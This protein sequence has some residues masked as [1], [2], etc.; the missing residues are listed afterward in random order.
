V[1]EV[2]TM[3]A[4]ERIEA[5]KV[6]I[7]RGDS[8]FSRPGQADVDRVALTVAEAMFLRDPDPVSAMREY[9]RAEERREGAYDAMQ[10]AKAAAEEAELYWSRATNDSRRAWVILQAALGR[11]P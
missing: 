8:P 2:I 11:H 5:A 9:Q 4:A 1:L 3:T 10:A 7:A 6:A